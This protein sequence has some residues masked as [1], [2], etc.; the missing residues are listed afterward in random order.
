MDTKD[1]VV[2]DPGIRLAQTGGRIREERE[3]LGWSQA[4]FAKDANVHRKTQINY[5][6]GER[7]PDSEYLQAIARLGVDVGYVLFGYSGEEE[8]RA[9]QAISKEL[10]GVLEVPD[11]YLTIGVAA[12]F[13]AQA[14]KGAPITE[15][16][17]PDFIRDIV[18]DLLK[19]SPV[20]L[21]G[22]DD[23]TDLIER[24]EFVAESAG[25]K[26][27]PPVKAKALFLLFQEKKR[28]GIDYVTLEM[29]REAIR[30]AA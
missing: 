3:R 2:N 28:S 7:K 26:L 22:P 25:T 16:P 18:R 20:L 27:T 29:V 17:N 30:Q 23:L 13:L 11:S 15:N 14:K 1:D 19:A 4:T 12:R 24:V 5:E 6:I 21:S 9:Y 8:L 10:M